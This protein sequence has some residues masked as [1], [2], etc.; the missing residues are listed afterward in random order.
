MPA[1]KGKNLKA[2]QAW[3]LERGCS[4]ERQ[5]KWNHYVVSRG[6]QQLFEFFGDINFAVNYD[7]ITKHDTVDEASAALKK[8]F[9]WHDLSQFTK[10][11][12]PK[13][14]FAAADELNQ[15]MSQQPQADA[16]AV[17]ALADVRAKKEK[18]VDFS[19][20]LKL[21]EKHDAYYFP[22]IKDAVALRIR[23]NRPVFL[24]G[25]AG[26]L[27]EDVQLEVQVDE[28]FYNFLKTNSFL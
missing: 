18:E 4:I 23:K 20:L 1:Q 5:E 2:L 14:S 24:S 16:A 10:P 11:A 12:V 25:G 26:C 27:G 9:Q 3:F 6:D 8:R 19:K 21:P 22:R 13:K 17:V 7:L 28:D 15:L